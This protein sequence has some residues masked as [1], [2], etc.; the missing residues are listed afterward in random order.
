[1]NIVA[2]ST[3]SEEEKKYRA[4]NGERFLSYLP[5][6]HIMEQIGFWYNLRAGVS[7]GFYSGDPL[8]IL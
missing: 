1:M 2:G 7:I 4:K 8:K 3:L 6:A 5:L